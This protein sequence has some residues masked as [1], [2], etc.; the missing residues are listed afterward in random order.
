M[1]EHTIPLITVRGS[2]AEVG[3]A[4]G[5]ACAA[6]IERECDTARWEIPPGRSVKDQLALA[7]RYAE[8][9]TAAAAV[10]LRGARRL[11]RGGRRR[12][13]SIVGR[14]HR[15][16]LVRAANRR[17]GRRRD[18]RSLQRSRRGPTGDRRRPYVDGPQQRHVAE[19]P[20]RPRGDRAH[21]R[22]RPD[23]PVDRQRDL[24]ERG[25]N[26]A[27]LN[28]TGNELSPNDERIGIPREIQVRAMLR[29]RTLEGM[30]DVALHP[31]R[32]SSYNNVLVDASGSVANVE[33]SATSAE[34]TAADDAA[35]WC[36]RTTTSAA[37][38]SR[39]RATPNTPTS[40]RPG[41]AA[42]RSCSQ[43]HRPG[44]SRWTCSTGSCRTTR[45]PP[46]PCA[47]TRPGPRPRSPRSGRSPT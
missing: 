21:V 32:A 12:S 11:R 29:E 36:T 2:Y 1:T 3:A 33:G 42:P 26:D 5:D 24:A 40:P 22:R 7:D 23:D 13:P 37:R 20:A 15:G 43:A 4:I 28:L 10:G 8:V 45:T 39:T 18:R 19:L 30:T 6:T 16:D 35:T 14:V 27:G 17:P 25:W 41:T 38:C 9:T 47:A 31:A 44:R 34:V 46:I